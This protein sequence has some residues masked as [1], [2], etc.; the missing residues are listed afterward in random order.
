MTMGHLRGMDRPG[1]R[2][3]AYAAAIKGLM[4]ADSGLREWQAGAIDRKSGY[5]V[6]VDGDTPCQR[7]VSLCF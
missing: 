4:E 3:M 2:A 7:F 5:I 1:D 6:L